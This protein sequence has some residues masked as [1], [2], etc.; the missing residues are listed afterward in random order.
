MQS[1]TRAIMRTILPPPVP[2][3]QHGEP[4]SQ[5]GNTGCPTRA[6][7]QCWIVTTHNSTK[8]HD[9]LSQGGFLHLNMFWKLRNWQ[10]NY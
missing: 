2:H 10:A 5:K 7:Q 8:P 9:I 3:A 4:E 6:A 1:H